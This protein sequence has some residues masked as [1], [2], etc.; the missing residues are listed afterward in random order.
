MKRRSFFKWLAGFT[1]IAP[2]AGAANII[3]PVAPKPLVPSAPG[4][5]LGKLYIMVGQPKIGKSRL[6]WC[7]ARHGRRLVGVDVD[8]FAKGRVFAGQDWWSITQA[9]R[10]NGHDVLVEMQVNR[11]SVN[12]L[13]AEV[14]GHF[15]W[16]ANDDELKAFY[17]ADWVFA[18]VGHT[19][20]MLPTADER[21]Y[22]YTIKDRRGN[23][24]SNFFYRYDGDILTR[25][26]YPCA[27]ST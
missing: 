20:K 23:D 21:W 7:M 19:R 12:Y 4:V 14:I 25:S 24:S 8:Q 10:D 11:A 3:T 1:A 16:L 26:V 6:A 5:S 27:A 13:N 17:M 2:V 18:V 15:S 9:L 22:C